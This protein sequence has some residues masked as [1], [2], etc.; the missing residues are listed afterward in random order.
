MSV[1]CGQLRQ[2]DVFCTGKTNVYNTKQ[3][4]TLCSYA[5]YTTDYMNFKK[6]LS[7]ILREHLINIKT[8]LQ[9]RK[10]TAFA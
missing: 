3:Y 5:A 7:Q 10:C 2:E 9:H 8:I 1:L 4:L 6:L